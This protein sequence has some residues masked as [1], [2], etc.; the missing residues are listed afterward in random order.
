MQNKLR[1][2]IFLL[3]IL[4]QSCFFSSNVSNNADKI[5][6][7]PIL[8]TKPTESPKF[9]KPNESLIKDKKTS[10][11]FSDDKKILLYKNINGSQ[12][13][14]FTELKVDRNGN[15]LIL[16]GNMLRKIENYIISDIEKKLYNL[17]D[18]TKKLSLDSAYNHKININSKGDGFI[19]FN[20]SQSCGNTDLIRICPI[21]KKYYIKCKDYKVISEPKQDYFDEI[22]IDESGNGILYTYSNVKYVKSTSENKTSNN[23]TFRKINKFDIS[24]KEE[25]IESL[26]SL[27]FNYKA[28]HLILSPKGDGEEFYF[29]D[30]TNIPILYMRSI[31]SFIPDRTYINKGQFSP[32]FYLGVSQ[33]QDKYNSSLNTNNLDENGNGYLHFRTKDQKMNVIP[34]EKFILK[35]EKSFIVNLNVYPKELDKNGNGTI[36]HTNSSKENVY[37]LEIQNILNYMPTEKKVIK[38]FINN[39]SLTGFPTKIFLDYLSK[40]E[41]GFIV[42]SEQKDA[43]TSE[44]YLKYMSDFSFDE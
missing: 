16:Y 8:N 26:N 13:L 28:P 29:D 10:I 21:P 36:F 6:D 27:E 14:N 37:D 33:Q 23:I 25:V 22:S 38:N 3:S 40:N 20:V 7:I 35:S 4:L 1:L 19:T 32:D 9:E 5:N 12:Q 42:W 43:N 24:D 39:N 2:N 34:I 15:G 41:K 11:D 17:D 44:I 18:L 30:S 31:S